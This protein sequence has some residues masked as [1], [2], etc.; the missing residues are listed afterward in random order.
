MRYTPQKSLF[1]ALAL[2]ALATFGLLVNA[3]AQ[4][5]YQVIAPEIFGSP[6]SPASALGNEI[7]ENG[8]TLF[9]RVASFAVWK[10]GAITHVASGLTD[11][12]ASLSRIEAASINSFQQVVGS[13]TYLIR[14]EAGTQFDTFPFYWDPANGLVDLDNLGERSASGIGNTSLYGINRNGLA[15]GAT[16]RFDG[17]ERAGTAAFTWSFESN[18]VAIAPLHSIDSYS[19]TLPQAVN[20]AGTVVGTYRSFLSSVDN[21]FERGFIYD[22]ENG[23]RDLVELAPDFFQTDHT[24][25]RDIN[26]KQSIVGERDG[27]AYFYDSESGTGYPIAAPGDSAG[28]TQAYALNE[29]DVVVGVA[30]NSKGT[31]RQG[32]SPI[33]WTRHTGTVALLPQIDRSLAKLLPEGLD[34]RDLRIT[35]KAINGSGE[36]SA[37]LESNGGFRR[38]VL[39]LPTL[40]FRWN[41]MSATTRNGVRGALYTHQKSETADLIPVAAL[42]LEIAFECSMDMKSWNSIDTE[43]DG[44]SVYEDD[45]RIELFVPMAHCVFVR[46]VLQQAAR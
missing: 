28:T 7:N 40:E 24:T 9:N 15:I 6:V 4:V 26:E 18:R 29:N 3:E 41:S 17:N 20:D 33:L 39:L 21:Y 23:S 45:Q 10:D 37:R 14:N 44:A 16:Q 13:K 34:S 2:G 5:R 42:G 31:N 8:E 22:S 12:P 46:P 19:V 35:P 11:Y 32:L 30:A 38:E 43:S 25:A 36:I 27:Q 1:T